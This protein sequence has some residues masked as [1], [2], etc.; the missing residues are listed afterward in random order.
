MQR[1]YAGNPSK[2]K[3]SALSNGKAKFNRVSAFTSTG[4]DKTYDLSSLAVQ[5]VEKVLLQ[6]GAIDKVTPKCYSLLYEANIKA[7]IPAVGL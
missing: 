6:K 1:Y 4:V 7:P 3:V 2:K 5:L